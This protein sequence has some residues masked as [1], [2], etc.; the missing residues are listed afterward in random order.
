ME[1]ICN[2]YL[3]SPA[4]P[5]NVQIMILCI[6]NY[7]FAFSGP[8]VMVVKPI[9]RQEGTSLSSRWYACFVVQRFW[10]PTPAPLPGPNIISEVCSAFSKSAQET[11]HLIRLFIPAYETHRWA[12]VWLPHN[13]NRGYVSANEFPIFSGGHDV[14]VVR[15]FTTNNMFL[16]ESVGGG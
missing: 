8:E 12:T 5:I 10:L 7:V 11:P 6:R 3:Q 9:S 15:T 2:N 14:V 1:I 4:V 16:E 13:S